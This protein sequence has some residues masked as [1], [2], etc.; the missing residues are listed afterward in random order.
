MSPLGLI[1]KLLRYIPCNKK[2]WGD[3]S[4][5]QP[6]TIDHVACGA[7]YAL[8]SLFL[9]KVY[10]PLIWLYL[11]FFVYHV[12]VIEIILDT[13]VRKKNSYL[14]VKDYDTVTATIILGPNI[15]DWPKV[16]AQTIERGICFVLLLPLV[17]I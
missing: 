4:F 15:I 13:L 5:Y 7:I 14:T 9:G 6:S 3:Q 17:F 11:A 12:I 2:Y 1:A 10:A 16:F 8:L